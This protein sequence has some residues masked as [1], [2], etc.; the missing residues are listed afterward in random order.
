MTEPLMQPTILEREESGE[1][2][3]PADLVAEDFGWP[4]QTFRDYMDRKLVFSRVERG[5]GE[6]IGTWRV[7]VRCGNRRWQAV[8]E[9][10]G[11]VRSRNVTVIQ[12]R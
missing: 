12:R 8:V 1:F 5:E 2:I 7:S 4:V 3:L 10:D 6:D 9:A 11:T